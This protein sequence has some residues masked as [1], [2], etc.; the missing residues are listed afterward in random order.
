MGRRN[1]PFEVGNVGDGDPKSALG[2][3]RGFGERGYPN[4]VESKGLEGSEQGEPMGF[5]APQGDCRTREGPLARGDPARGFSNTPRWPPL[6]CDAEITR[7]H[8][9]IITMHS[10]ILAET[11]GNMCRDKVIKGLLV[12]E[13]N[14]GHTATPTSHGGHAR[15]LSE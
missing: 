10:A 4:R 9:W 13:E 15:S 7:L 3:A 11:N 12:R 6:R 14:D 1:L 8:D 5:I 2:F